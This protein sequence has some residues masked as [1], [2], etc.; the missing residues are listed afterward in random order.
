MNL[1]E[2]TERKNTMAASTILTLVHNIILK[3]V[4]TYELIHQRY[5][6]RADFI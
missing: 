5:A 3:H 6:L 1:R 4:L 2:Q